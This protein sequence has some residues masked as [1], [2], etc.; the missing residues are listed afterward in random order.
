MYRLI[1]VVIISVLIIPSLTLEVL[2]KCDKAELIGQWKRLNIN[3]PPLKMTT[4]WIFTPNFTGADSG[5]ISCEGDCSRASGKPLAY[6]L[7]QPVMTSRMKVKFETDKTIY[8]CKVEGDNLVLGPMK[9][10]R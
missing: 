6:E 7:N 5:T 2:A 8:Y 9:F 4:Y 1:L 10:I 3:D